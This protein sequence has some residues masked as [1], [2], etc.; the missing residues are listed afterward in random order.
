M[1]FN[2]SYTNPGSALSFGGKNATARYSKLS[3]K[4]RERKLAQT[5][6]YVLHR[7]AKRPRIYNPIILY[8]KRELLQA[9]LI[10]M[11]SKGDANSGRKYIL[12]I[13]DAFTRKCWAASLVTKTTEAVLAAFKRLYANIGAFQRLMT[14][15]GTEFLSRK[16][17]SFLKSEKIEFTRGNPHAPHVERLNRTL[18]SKLFK[19]MTENE[20]HNWEKVLLVVVQAYND[21]YHRIIKMT[22]NAA[23]KAANQTE[24]IANVRAY[25][26]K[27]LN[28]RK[29]PKFKVGD[30]VSIQK[31]GSVFAKGYH[32]VFTDHLYKIAE[33][34]AALPIPMYSLVDY[35]GT[36]KIEGRFYENELQLAD[37]DV[38]KV[39]S[40]LDN[41]VNSKGQREVFVK[42]KGWPE[43]YNSWQPE[44]NIVRDF[45]N[46]FSR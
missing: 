39:E 38:F 19:Y 20:T 35:D 36:E 22:P 17:Q 44:K 24:L 10:D 33:V 3:A 23:E 25:Y 30:Q 14:D 11:R 13:C 43:K 45:T 12:I 6:T 29:T 4:K 21:R 9:D 15:A 46:K 26:E 18:Q 32:Q 41:R 2:K 1:S 28:K 7:E 31:L 27:A 5:P 40:V 42:W 8:K 37:Y 16:F 34:H